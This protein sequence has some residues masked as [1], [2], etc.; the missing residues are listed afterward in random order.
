M[1]D[2]L[3]RAMASAL[4]EVTAG[5]VAPA[6]KASTPFSVVTKQEPSLA[7]HVGRHISLNTRLKARLRQAITEATS[8]YEERCG[9]IR[10]EFGAKI[11]RA[12]G[13]LEEARD[14]ELRFALKRY[15]ERLSE[16]AELQ[17]RMTL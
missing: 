16:L 1:T 2:E 17:Q 9:K 5:A 4:E 12:L 8:E 10:T 13:E 14:S 15:H 3:E 11:D 6:T 7:D